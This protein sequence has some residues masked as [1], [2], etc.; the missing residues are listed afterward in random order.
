MSSE[1]TSPVFGA[2]M[3][4]LGLGMTVYRNSKKQETRQWV[5]YAIIMFAFT[6][7]VYLNPNKIFNNSSDAL[8]TLAAIGIALLAI[9][10]FVDARKR[11]KR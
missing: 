10:F 11:R 8:N 9:A 2:I 1:I 6:A 7:I 5:A 4:V 3:G